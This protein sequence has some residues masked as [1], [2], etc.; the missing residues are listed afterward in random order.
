[1]TNRDPAVHAFAPKPRS[2]LRRARLFTVDNREAETE[3]GL[4]LILPLAH[5]AGRSGN[6][7]VVDA[8]AELS[9]RITRPASMVL[10][11]PTSSAIS[12]FTARQP[13]RLAEREKLVGIE[14]DPGPEWRL[15]QILIGRSLRIPPQR[16]QITGENVGVVGARPGDALPS[17]LAKPLRIKLGIPDD[18]RGLTLRVIIDAGQFEGYQMLARL[19]LVL[20]QPPPGSH[21]DKIFH[22]RRERHPAFRI[23]VC[24]WVAMGCRPATHPFSQRRGIRPLPFLLVALSFRRTRRGGF[25]ACFKRQ[26]ERLVVRFVEETKPRKTGFV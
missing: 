19:A 7:D 25:H 15:K 3:L 16:P 5:H 26:R 8:A 18:M 20:D 12:R 10:L 23:R 1:M 6:Q 22:H 11:A 14:P 17:L 2:R 9:L 13:E 21:P 24:D 4:Q